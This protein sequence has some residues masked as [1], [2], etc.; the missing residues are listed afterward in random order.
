MSEKSYVPV[1][2]TTGHLSWYYDLSTYA[3]LSFLYHHVGDKFSVPL[4]YYT[5]AHFISHAKDIHKIL[6][7]A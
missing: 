2:L 1:S 3:I 5:D 6:K 4:I 7:F